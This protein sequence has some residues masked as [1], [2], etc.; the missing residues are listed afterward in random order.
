MCIFKSF[1]FS[2]IFVLLIYNCWRQS[3]TNPIN[4]FSIWKIWQIPPKPNRFP[5]T[6]KFWESLTEH[7]WQNNIISRSHL[8]LHV[9]SFMEKCTATLH[10]CSFF[11]RD[12]LTRSSSC[13]WD[14][15]LRNKSS[16]FLSS[17]S[18]GPALICHVSLIA[19]L[20]P[21][22]RKEKICF[23][24]KRTK[25]ARKF[26]LPQSVLSVTWHVRARNFLISVQ[27]DSG[28]KIVRMS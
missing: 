28:K 3:G 22:A 19:Q 1:A 16:I 15:W 2:Y 8:N 17:F 6:Q 24:T 25:S 18:P 23:K 5:I 9:L 14:L 27:G 7:P 21:S 11:G 13:T 20:S 12:N 4:C 26:G 10:N